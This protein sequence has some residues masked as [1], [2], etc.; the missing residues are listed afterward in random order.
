MATSREYESIPEIAIAEKLSPGLIAELLQEM[1]PRLIAINDRVQREYRSEW[2]A[3]LASAFSPEEARSVAEFYRSPLGAKV[4]GGVA[5]NFTYD[6][7]IANI[8]ETPVITNQQVS[9]DM[10]RTT[11]GLLAELTLADLEEMGLAAV[12]NPAL[13]KLGELAPQMAELRTRMENEQPTAAEEAAIEAAVTGVFE[14][15]FEQ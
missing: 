5:R 7:T 12:E 1:R 11:A 9:A 8:A 14:R 13:L 2:K 6:Q 10:R 3:L 4:L 15:R